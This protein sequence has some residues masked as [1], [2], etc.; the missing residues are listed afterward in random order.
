MIK[1]ISSTLILLLTFSLTVANSQSLTI[2]GIVKNSKTDEPIP[3]VN[4]GIRK[5]N[6]GT[7][8]DLSGRFRLTIND[9]NRKDTITFSGVGFEEL[10]LSIDAILSD[11]QTEFFLNEKATSLQEV[12]VTNRARKIRKVGTISRNPLVT[13]TAQTRNSNDIS[14]LANLIKLNQTPSELLSATL[15]LK[16]LKID[17][18]SFRINFLDSVD[19]EPGDRI[20]EKSIIR[21]LPLTS[22][23]VTVD[24]EQYN[25]VIEKDFFI[26]FEYLPDPNYNE[27]FLFYY[28]GALGGNYYSRNVSL[29]NWKK[30][31]G[32][33]IAAYVTVRQ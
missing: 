31:N 18:A 26:S 17:S 20:V 11:R 9:E 5:K 1:R 3:Y 4:I 23:W 25:I 12:V 10:S 8:A 27:K 32:A 29:G 19:G 21:R 24:L 14:E 30:G 6:I 22:G 13:G 16:S 33:R 2:S 15:Y 7:A 28:G